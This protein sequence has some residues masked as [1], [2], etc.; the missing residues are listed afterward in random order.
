MRPFWGHSEAILRPRWGH[1]EDSS[2]GDPLPSVATCVATVV[3]TIT[4]ILIFI[5]LHVPNNLS[6][7]TAFRNTFS[8]MFR[9]HI[10]LVAWLRYLDV[11]AIYSL[12]LNDSSMI[13][14]FAG[15]ICSSWNL[16]TLIR[17]NRKYKMEIFIIYNFVTFLFLYYKIIFTR[18]EREKF[19]LYFVTESFEIIFFAS[20]SFVYLARRIAIIISFF[21][22]SWCARVLRLCLF[23]SHG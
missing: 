22:L 23:V 14:C 8:L 2:E 13:T 20:L 18:N 5:G 10:F 11:S 9:L 19:Q 4:N 17:G 12:F 6:L 1:V 3:V 21:L 16:K 15:I 7:S